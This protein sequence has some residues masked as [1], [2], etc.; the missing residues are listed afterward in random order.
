MVGSNSRPEGRKSTG[1][2]FWLKLS[3]GLIIP[4]FVAL[5]IFTPIVTDRHSGPRQNESAAVGSLRKLN[6]LESQYSAAHANRS[7]ACELPLLRP[8]ER[9]NEAYDSTAALL[10]GEWSGYKF[11]VVGCA[12]ETGGIVTHYQAIAIPIDPGKTGIRAF[13][14]DQSGQLF[15]DPDGS[16]SKCLASRRPI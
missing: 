8:T 2:S 12:A 5:L 6:T 16:A 13:C 4:I 9:M 7:F 11:I 10:A 3:V 15:Y 1:W 14:T